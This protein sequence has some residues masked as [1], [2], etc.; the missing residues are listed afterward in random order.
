MDV[1]ALLPRPAGPCH[2]AFKA[3]RDGH[4]DTK[5]NAGAKKKNG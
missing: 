4:Y 3:A 1:S 2:L 5:P